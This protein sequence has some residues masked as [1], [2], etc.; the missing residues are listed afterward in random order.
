MGEVR[1]APPCAHGVA[2][3]EALK[4]PAMARGSICCKAAS[5]LRAEAP[6][7][8][9]Q[10][11]EPWAGLAWRR[12]S[13]SS[14]GGR[15]SSAS[16]TSLPRHRIPPSAPGMPDSPGGRGAHK[17]F[18]AVLLCPAGSEPSL[19]HSAHTCGFWSSQSLPVLSMRLQ[20]GE[21]LC[22]PSRHPSM[23]TPAG[24]MVQFMTLK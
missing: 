7:A 2:S 17:L 6:A 8:G 24:W 19:S 11:G 10:E 14:R 18:I 23:G 22:S 20:E 21:H 5:P 1:G 13:R 4:I 16:P 15:G 3:G 9:P 12:Q